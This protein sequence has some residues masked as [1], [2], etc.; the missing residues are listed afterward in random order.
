MSETDFSNLV[1]DAI[2]E[3]APGRLVV[4]RAFDIACASIT[5]LLFLPL[6]A[7]IAL[8]VLTTSRGGALFRQTRVGQ[9]GRPFVMYKFRT[10]KAG[11]SDQIHR[12]YVGKLM[13][14]DADPPTGGERG[15]Y[16]LEADPRVT[17]VGRFLRRSSL[18][19]LP[20]LWNVLR[21][22]MTLV[23]PRPCL[24]YEYALQPSWHRLRYRVT[25]GLTGPWQAYGR[26]LV[27]F[28]EMALMDY[29]YGWTKSFWLDTWL[30]LRTVWVVISG[31]G[32][33]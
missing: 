4:K 26:S 18:D 3:R 30:I 25:P 33:K 22:D 21:G 32:G 11:S 16:K 23:G 13:A 28:D 29:C 7:V 2:T 19:E 5:L 15:L 17:R 10:M 14:T 24:P 6:F 20:Q 1:A 27:S 9:L 12:E 31:E 8:L